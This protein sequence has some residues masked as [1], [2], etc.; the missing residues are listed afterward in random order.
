MEIKKTSFEGVYMIIPQTFE[1][2]RGFFRETFRKNLLEE[3]VGHKIDFSKIQENHSRSVKNTLRGI[4]VAPWSKLIYCP[5]GEVQAVFVDLRKE[6]KTFLQHIS[7]IIGDKNPIKLFIPPGVGNSYLVLSDYADYIYS[8]DEY[9]STGCEQG[10][11]WN[12]PDLKIK[13]MNLTEPNLSEKDRNNPTIK[14]LFEL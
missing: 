14:T 13:W 5:H 10:I 1:D 7:F 3:A 12:D 9:W 11:L 8:V 2:E 6:S 4:H